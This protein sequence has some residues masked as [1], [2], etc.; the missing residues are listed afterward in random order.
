MVRHTVAFRL[1]DQISSFEE[2]NFFHE[3]RKL[4]SIPG[5]KNFECLKQIS[6]NNNFD[7]GLSM[8]FDTIELY[9]QYSD[10]PDHNRFVQK[11]WTKYVDDYLELDY[12]PL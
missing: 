8:E 12:E 6:K 4:V 2:K 3:I 5:V 7:Y 1:K 9:E 11:Y 10:H